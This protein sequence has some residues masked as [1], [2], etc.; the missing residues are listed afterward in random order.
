MG[1]V[2]SDKFSLKHTTFVINFDQQ[3]VIR[4]RR[5]I[6]GFLSNLRQSQLH[7]KS[8]GILRDQLY[9]H[10][11]NQRLDIADQMWH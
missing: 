5:F 4:F 6:F 11:S 3:I 9:I 10:V 1:L 2:S 8:V 7:R